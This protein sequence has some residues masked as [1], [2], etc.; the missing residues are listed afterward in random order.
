[1]KTLIKEVLSESYFFPIILFFFFTTK[2]CF[3]MFS[4]TVLHKPNEGP[5]SSLQRFRVTHVNIILP[6][7]FIYSG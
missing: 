5:F 4:L 7:V 1:M 3:Q 2:I 6:T